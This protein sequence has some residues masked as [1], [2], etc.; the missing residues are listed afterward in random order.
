ME[1]F[2]KKMDLIDFH[3]Y[4]G[5]QTWDKPGRLIET[6]GGK[7]RQGSLIEQE[8]IDWDGRAL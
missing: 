3:E 7:F 4:W 6:F 8:T 5:S 1:T 2:P